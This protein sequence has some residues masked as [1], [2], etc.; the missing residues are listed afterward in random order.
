MTTEESHELT[1]EAAQAKT[2]QTTGEQDG[3]RGPAGAW[4]A[5]PTSL[6]LIYLVKKEEDTWHRIQ[7][8]TGVVLG[9]EHHLENLVKRI[10]RSGHRRGFEWPLGIPTACGCQNLYK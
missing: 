9:G 2:G 4:E 3:S 1:E 8:L 10:S 6:Y 5:H 7:N